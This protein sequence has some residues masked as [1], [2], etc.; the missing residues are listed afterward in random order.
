MLP[1]SCICVDEDRRWRQFIAWAL[2]D[3][4]TA[5]SHFRAF[6]MVVTFFCIRV[7]LFRLLSR[8]QAYYG[9]V[10]TISY[11]AICAMSAIK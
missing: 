4:R 9:D 5:E 3:V 6:V 8:R 7:T 10:S 11:F 1:L 2:I